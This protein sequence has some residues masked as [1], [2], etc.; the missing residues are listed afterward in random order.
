LLPLPRREAR[1]MACRP[2]SRESLD[3][4]RNLRGD[5]DSR[6]D[7]CLALLLAGVELYIRS[8]HELELL[9]MMRNRAEDM[10]EAVE[11]TPS[12]EDLRRLFER[13]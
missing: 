5:A 9:E 12:A 2:T 7:D 6:G 1:V 13:E 10:R 11:N 4:L 3:Q 8:G